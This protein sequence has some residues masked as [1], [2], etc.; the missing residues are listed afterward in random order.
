MFM[1]INDIK[2][3]FSKVSSSPDFQSQF[4]IAAMNGDLETVKKLFETKSIDP[5][6]KMG[7]Q[8]VFPLYMAAQNGHLNVVNYLLS[9]NVNVNLTVSHHQMTALHIALWNSHTEIAKAILAKGGVHLNAQAVDGYTAL[10]CAAKRGFP[11]SVK[12]LLTLNADTAIKDDGGQT[13]LDRAVLKNHL[14]IA[15]LLDGAEQTVHTA[16][17]QRMKVLG[18]KLDPEGLCFGFSQSAK[19]CA[20]SSEEALNIFYRTIASIKDFRAS[21]LLQIQEFHDQLLTQAEIE[22]CQAF[23]IRSVKSL[24]ETQLSLFRKTTIEKLTS[25]RQHFTKEEEAQEVLYSD[26]MALFNAIELEHQGSDK[27]AHLLEKHSLCLLKNNKQF[28]IRKPHQSE[29]LMVLGKQGSIRYKILLSDGTIK[30]FQ[31][32]YKELS[33]AFGNKYPEFSDAL[34]SRREENLRPFAKKI[35]EIISSKS[36]GL[37]GRHF[38]QD[39]NPSWVTPLVQ[40]QA[41]EKKGGEV[42]LAEF[43]GAYKKEEIPIFFASLRNR[44]LENNNLT[45][46]V[47]LDLHCAFHTISLTFDPANDC[48]EIFS[49]NDLSSQPKEIKREMIPGSV[50][51]AER[52]QKG[53]ATEPGNMILEVNVS[54]TRNNLRLVKPAIAAWLKD[55]EPLH[56]ITAE[57]V[58]LTNSSQESWLY[59][60]CKTGKVKLVSELL[61]A[62]ASIQS[63][64]SG[65]R[66][67][68]PLFEAAEHGY[69]SIVNMLLSQPGVIPN[70]KGKK[71]ATALHQAAFGGHVE[72]VKRLLEAKWDPNSTNDL[73]AT[74]LLSAMQAGQS[75]VVKLLLQMDN[76]TL[77]GSDIGGVSLLSAAADYGHLEALQILLKEKS[78]ELDPNE[79]DAEGQTALQRATAHGHLGVVQAFL[80]APFQTKIDV[81]CQ[82]QDT[83]SALYWAAQAG[84]VEIAQALIEAKADVNAAYQARTPAVIAAQKGHAGIINVLAEVKADF[85]KPDAQGWTPL[86]LATF[87]GHT[88]TVQAFTEAKVNLNCQI[89]GATPV[90]VAVEQEHI[91]ILKVLIEA[92]ADLNTTDFKGKSP[93]HLAIIKANSQNLSGLGLFRPVPL[94]Y[95][96]IDLLLKAGARADIRDNSGKL[97]IEYANEAVKQ[98]IQK[99]TPQDIPGCEQF[100]NLSVSTC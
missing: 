28:K 19:I 57:R 15:S 80:S 55:L 4:L 67:K 5:N 71:G 74:P 88:Q 46:K 87:F 32:M 39:E 51:I 52:V 99:M 48:W 64:G 92:K 79:Q 7:A 61:A 40:P 33:R 81:N 63:I 27:H 96:S 59:T 47:A 43:I 6:K 17:L 62:G 49:I 10:H 82:T 53:F 97:P 24:D 42:K 65:E 34:N 12:L 23:G 94:A 16:L 85:E 35:I 58:N 75:E 68:N 84:R 95:E 76:I 54:S 25:L 83:P 31:I 73:G 44:L 37:E 9:I 21:E 8:S 26:M 3:V 30:E 1:F 56:A 41:F 45:E 98:Y 50:D 29:V 20:L 77:R 66:I 2:K 69:L 100:S 14:D 72:V 36:H 89:N 78:Q 93:L 18:F 86:L 22:T 91:P 11:A 13:A 70:E 90:S 38:T 60:A